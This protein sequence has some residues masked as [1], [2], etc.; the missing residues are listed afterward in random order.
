M[1]SYVSSHN[2]SP[3]YLHAMSQGGF[4]RQRMLNQIDSQ[5]LSKLSAAC[6]LGE[7][8]GVG[9]EVMEII[10][11]REGVS[12]QIVRVWN[13]RLDCPIDPSRDEVLTA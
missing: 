8:H 2:T 6:A 5:R 4:N 9:G 11:R 13:D 10:V 3:T 12:E 1:L 7:V